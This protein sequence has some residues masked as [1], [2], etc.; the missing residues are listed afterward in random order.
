MTMGGWN[1]PQ[2]KWANP[3]PV[4]K[5]A[6]RAEALRKYEEWIWTQPHLMDSLEELRGKTLGCWCK[7]KACHGDILVRLM[8]ERYKGRVG[9]L[10]GNDRFYVRPDYTGDIQAPRSAQKGLV[11]PALSDADI[12]FVP[13]NDGLIQSSQKT[14]WKDMPM[15]AMRL[16]GN[17]TIYPRQLVPVQTGDIQASRYAQKGLVATALSEAEL[18]SVFPKTGELIIVALKPVDEDQTC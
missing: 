17:D 6:E 5:E 9:Q 8:D 4:K 15:A 11:A 18:P 14:L 1:L 13:P 12:P 16:T 3:F 2:S 7:P 10:T